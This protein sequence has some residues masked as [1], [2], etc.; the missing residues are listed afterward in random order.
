MSSVILIEDDQDLRS[1]LQAAIRAH[2]FSVN[3]YDSGDTFLNGFESSD[4]NELFVIDLN[5]GGTPGFEVCRQIK[6][7]NNKSVVILISA[8]PEVEELAK[9]ACADDFMIKPFAQK[10]LIKK[11][12]ELKLK[13]Q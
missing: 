5:L 3:C 2:G 11:I 10:D 1:L 13:K 7:A 12:H 9:K 6:S 4:D 8:N